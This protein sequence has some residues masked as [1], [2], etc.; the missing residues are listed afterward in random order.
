MVEAPLS[1]PSR[2]WKTRNA[3]DWKQTDGLPPI[4]AV[5]VGV[6]R[7]RR[8]RGPHAAGC[9]VAENARGAAGHALQAGSRKPHVAQANAELL[10]GIGN[11]A[12][13]ELPDRIEDR[14]VAI[15]AADTASWFVCEDR[16]Q[17]VRQ[18]KRA[19]S[20]GDSTSWIQSYVSASARK[21]P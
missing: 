21:I 2:S 3:G 6:A 11:R 19:V 17:A 13:I 15:V 16:I 18:L 7:H 14:V 4:R 12:G 1:I 9:R 10:D 5:D 8:V 20:D